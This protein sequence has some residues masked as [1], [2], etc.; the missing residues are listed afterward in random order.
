MST[1]E[2]LLYAWAAMAVL[3]TF[4]W[5]IQRITHN[6]GI[7]DVAWS[8]GTAICAVW[9]AFG[10]QGF[11][12][13]RV[14]VG[15]MVGIWGARL[16]SYLLVRLIGAHEDRRYSAMREKWGSN[17]Q[18]Y[19]FGIFQIQA[20]WAVL[21]AL[22][23]FL[24]A[25]ND[26]PALRW[27]DYLGVALWLVSILG[28]SISD[29]QLHRFRKI[30]SNK[31]KVCRAGLWNYSRHPNYF[32]EW[33]HWWAYVAIGLAGTWGWATLAGPAVM[34]F[35]LLKLTGIPITERALVASRG[36][37]YRAYQRTTSAFIPLPPKE[38]PQ[39]KE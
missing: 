9:F 31:G 18:L 17:T 1:I 24:A 5:V 20:F 16:G 29:R 4:L 15:V 11:E 32:F 37:A 34:L 8:F 35:F 39:E 26:E 38:D 22:P 12:A 2:L 33:I 21:F 10:A 7:V 3:M 13:R 36:D 25:S 19:M 23:M 28:A 14:L 27:Y 6:A 30:D